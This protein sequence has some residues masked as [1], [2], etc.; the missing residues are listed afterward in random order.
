MISR[1]QSSVRPRLACELLPDRVFA[2]RAAERRDLVEAHTTRSLPAGTLAPALTTANVLDAGS[3]SR[4]IEDAL[5]AVSGRTRDVC[6][7]LP[8]SAVRI[9]LLDFDTLP[10]NH[11]DALGVIRFRLRKSL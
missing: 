2:G 10:D 6:A 1:M 5:G 7:I 3:L 4:A 9:V 11:E 8:D